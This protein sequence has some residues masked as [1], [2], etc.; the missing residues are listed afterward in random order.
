MNQ[1]VDHGQP[2]GRRNGDDGET[3]RGIAKRIATSLLAIFASIALFITILFTCFQ[4]VAFDEGRY[5]AA[6]QKYGLTA[7]TGMSQEDLTK[8]THEL[9]RYCRGRL[10]TLDMQ[11]VINGQMREV[12]DSREKAHM[13]DVQKLFVG[14][15]KLRTIC[16]ISFFFFLLLL[17]YVSR[18]RFIK[19]LC[20][21]W[22]ITVAVL[23][24]LLVALGIY[25]AIDFNTAFI[26]FHHIFFTNDLWQLYENEVLIQMLP[27]P[28]FDSIAQAIIVSS[29]A[30]LAVVTAAAV[31]GLVIIRKK[32]GKDEHDVPE[33][34]EIVPGEPE[35]DD[36]EAK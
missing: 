24:G 29:V 13:V 20:R 4:L 9:L 30:S 5:L 19:E 35:P 8:V 26:Q 7:V 27:E 31:T 17:I 36:N 6:Q 18:R 1:D 22:I 34:I 25:C 10:H 23:G 14:G 21:A 12:F 3:A 11:S 16:I 32:A 15:F 2:D 33:D 28:F